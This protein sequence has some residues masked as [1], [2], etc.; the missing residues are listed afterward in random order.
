MEHYGMFLTIPCLDAL[1][2]P[3]VVQ[4]LLKEA[5]FG[6]GTNFVSCKYCY[7]RYDLNKEGKCPNCGGTQPQNYSKV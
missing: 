6:A 3:Y 1:T 2:E 4:K 5:I 7:A